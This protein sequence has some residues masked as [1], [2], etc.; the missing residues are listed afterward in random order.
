MSLRIIAGDLKGRKLKTV[1]GT[2]TRPTANRTREAIFN[3]LAPQFV[4]CRVLDLFAG[5]GAFGIE[6]LSRGAESAV[7]ID[8]DPDSIAILTT[9]LKTLCLERQTKIIRWN[10]LRDLNCLKSLPSPFEL[11]ELVFMDPP[12]CRNMIEPALQNLHRSQTLA[13]GTQVVVEHSYREP[14]AIGR[15]PLEI[16]DR[17]QYGKTLVTILNYV[18]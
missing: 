10:M 1:R 6:A 8:I 16:A 18:I 17:R 4:G 9:N 12:Y 13:N 5:N 7:F 15:L 2:K 3:I 14:V 11:F